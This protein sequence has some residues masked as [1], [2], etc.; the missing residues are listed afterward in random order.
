[1]KKIMI[2]AGEASGD[3][4]G[5]S[6]AREIRKA[7][8]SIALYGVGSVRMR[9][10]GVTMLADASDISVV[11][12]TEVIK[13]LGSIY[14]TYRALKRFLARERPN[15]LVL[16]DLPDFNIM[17]G[18]AAKKIGIP[19][20]Y[21]ISPQVWAWRKGRIKTIARLVNAMIVIFPF[22]EPLVSKRRR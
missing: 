1:M 6:L 22:E 9:E 15:L 18:K 8:P 10:A 21:Y 11:G 4:H 2:M 16:I 17:L 5:S 13:H 3:L 7:D 14:R 20:V 12:L 19:I